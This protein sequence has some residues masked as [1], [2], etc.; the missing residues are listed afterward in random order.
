MMSFSGQTL[1]ITLLPSA[2][3]GLYHPTTEE[4]NKVMWKKY[5]FYKEIYIS[6]VTSV[7][8]RVESHMHVLF[9]TTYWT[10]IPTFTYNHVNNNTDQ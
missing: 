6:A 1:A 4:Q 10:L 7:L 8:N 2:G 3:C 5:G 9:M